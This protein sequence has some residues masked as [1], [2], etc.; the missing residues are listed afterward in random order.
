[1]SGDRVR[2][3]N[4]IIRITQCQWRQCIWKPFLGI[5]INS[6]ANNMAKPSVQANCL[7]VTRNGILQ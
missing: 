6:Y 3:V 7:P 5:L 4:I 1:M 2:V